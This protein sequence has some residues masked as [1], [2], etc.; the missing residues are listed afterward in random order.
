MHASDVDR[1]TLRSADDGGLL[2]DAAP[3]KPALIRCAEHPLST[4]ARKEPHEPASSHPV[5]LRFAARKCS[6]EVTGDPANN[7]LRDLF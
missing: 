7:R 3:T 2:T 6:E 1:K 4:G 5:P